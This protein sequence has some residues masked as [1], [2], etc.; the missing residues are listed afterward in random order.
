MRHSEFDR[1]T[2]RYTLVLSSYWGLYA[3]LLGYGSHY[4][5]V[6]GFNNTLI[7]LILALGGGLS[8]LLQTPLASLADRPKGPNVRSIALALGGILIL[9]GAAMALT[10]RKCLPLEGVLFCLC[11]CLLQALM[12]MMNALAME[13]I[14]QGKALAYG[15]ARG[16]G[17]GAYAVVAFILG[18]SIREG[19]GR[20]NLIFTL[21][22]SAALC[23]AIWFFPFEKGKKNAPDAAPNGDGKGFF[24]RYP[25]FTFLLSGA[26]LAFI[27]HSGVNNFLYQLVQFK[28]GTAGEQGILMALS[29]MMEMPPMFLFAWLLKHGK[30][31]NYLRLSGI[32]FF[33]K[34]LLTWLAPG[35]GM[36]YGVQVLQFFA[37]GLNA[38]AFTYYVNALMAPQDTVKGQAC[39]SSAIILGSVFC[40]LV[41]GAL[42]DAWG[43]NAMLI[44]STVCG[45]VGAVM[46]CA[47]TEKVTPDKKDAIR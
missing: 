20:M 21:V 30:C 15:T 13:S 10:Y 24:R 26:V 2:V 12:P 47:F 9:T 39:I 31:E 22:L 32:A 38:M 18:Q 16:I 28:G 46:I 4:L 40:S 3:G 45:A 5:S 25:R 8:A 11:A 42:I 17:A 35:M 19:D 27:C 14:N 33:L 41:G 44:F 23:G 1:L 7:G 34:T 36:Y 37:W 6:I 29:V 43:V